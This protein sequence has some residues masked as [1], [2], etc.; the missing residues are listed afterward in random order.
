MYCRISFCG[1]FRFLL[2]LVCLLSAAGGLAN[3]KPVG[4]LK[5]ESRY[6]ELCCKK[7]GDSASAPQSQSH[8]FFVH[9]DVLSS[10]RFPPPLL[11]LPWS[12]QYCQ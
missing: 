5:S 6:S 3:L 12:S 4:S 10:Y 9:L 11:L 8:L 2:A 7:Q 1:F